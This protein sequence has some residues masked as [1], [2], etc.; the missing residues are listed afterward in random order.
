[1]VS[2]VIPIGFSGRLNVPLAVTVTLALTLTLTL[3]LVP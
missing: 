1:M 3:T 2:G